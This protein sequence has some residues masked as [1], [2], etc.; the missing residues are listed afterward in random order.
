MMSACPGDKSSVFPVADAWHQGDP[1]QRRQAKDRRA[2]RLGIAVDRGGLNAGEVLE[3]AV[4]EINP[5]PDPAGDE[6]REQ[7]DT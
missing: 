2:L 7:G 4:E 5:L 1:Q 3:Q 6:V